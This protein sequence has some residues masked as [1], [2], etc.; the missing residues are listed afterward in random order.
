[1]LLVT[2]PSA[3]FRRTVEQN[4]VDVPLEGPR[5]LAM[6][7]NVMEAG[8][9]LHDVGGKPVH[10]DVALVIHHDALRSVIEHEALDHIVERR[11][12][13]MF[14]LLQPSLRFLVLLRHPPD[15]HEKQHGD[16]AVGKAGCSDQEFGLGAPVGER[17]FNSPGGDNH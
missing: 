15:N 8:A 10:V 7:Y 13:P 16:H 9:R 14:F 6:P 2:L 4:F 5:L 12:Q 3:T 17:R 1:M 11:V